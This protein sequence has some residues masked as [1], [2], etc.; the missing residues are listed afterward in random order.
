[1]SGPMYLEHFMSYWLPHGV[2]GVISMEGFAATVALNVR[3]TSEKGPA[4]AVSY[5]RSLVPHIQSVLVG[6]EDGQIISS[7]D[8]Y[9]KDVIAD[10][11]NTTNT[12][13][14]RFDRPP[15]KP[16]DT[17]G[18]SGKGFGKNTQAENMGRPHS[19]ASSMVCMFHDPAKGKSCRNGSTCAFRHL[20]TRESGN[21]RLFEESVRDYNRRKR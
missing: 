9:I 21:K 14:S 20:D 2:A 4:F 15:Y 3:L 18:K 1:M 13:F 5:F 10:V 6:K 7:L 8:P 17:K 19:A 11:K 12:S 16:G